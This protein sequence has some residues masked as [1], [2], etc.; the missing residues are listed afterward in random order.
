MSVRMKPGDI[1]LTRI[2][3]GA[4]SAAICVVITLTAPLEAP[5]KLNLCNG[6]A[7]CEAKDAISTILPPVP[8]DRIA[9][10]ASWAEKNVPKTY[11]IV[12]YC[13]LK[14]IDSL[15]LTFTFRTRSH[16]SHS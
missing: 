7:L 1:E 6:I 13:S 15:P 16:S 8:W 10:A 5:Y 3:Q 12:R 11:D 9:F 14:Y 2:F 4:S